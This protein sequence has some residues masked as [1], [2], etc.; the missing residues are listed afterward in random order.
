[1]LV[2]MIAGLAHKGACYQGHELFKKIDELGG[3][4]VGYGYIGFEHDTDRDVGFCTENVNTGWWSILYSADDY[5]MWKLSPKA[6]QNFADLVV[7]AVRLPKV[8]AEALKKNNSHKFV[9]EK[10]N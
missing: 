10:K 7:S 6:L 1:M 5:Y 2:K 9:V 8:D 3:W 4:P